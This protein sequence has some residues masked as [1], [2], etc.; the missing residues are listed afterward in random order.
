MDIG[1]RFEL[2]DLVKPRFVGRG[3]L[4]SNINYY[5][6]IRR[7]VHLAVLHLCRTLMEVPREVLQDSNTSLSGTTAVLVL[8]FCL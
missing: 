5:T 1:L 6:E 8:S 7:E 3:H 2:E 4:W